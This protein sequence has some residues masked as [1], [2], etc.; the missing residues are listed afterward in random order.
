[1]KKKVFFILAIFSLHLNV[2]AIDASLNIQRPNSEPLYEMRA[3][4]LTTIGGR[5][6]PHSYSQSK[7]S[8]QK[9]KQELCAILDKLSAAGVNTVLL[10]TRIRAT[11]IFPSETEPWDGCLSGTP[12]MSPGYDALAFAIEECHKRGIKLR[13][14]TND[15]DFI[16]NVQYTTFNTAGNNRTTAGN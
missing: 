14:N 8:M 12:G 11:T 13:F 4:W 10:Q 6:W 15:F 9:Q 7:Y 1:M 16:A 5:D 3:V 2:F